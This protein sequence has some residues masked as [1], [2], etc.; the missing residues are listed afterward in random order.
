[1]WCASHRVPIGERTGSGCRCHEL[2][3]CATDKSASGLGGGRGQ[4]PTHVQALLEQR[5]FELAERT[6]DLQRCKNIVS[7]IGPTRSNELTDHSGPKVE[8]PSTERGIRMQA[9]LA[10]A[11]SESHGQGVP[12]EGLVTVGSPRSCVFCPR[13]PETRNAFPCG[14]DAVAPTLLRG[15]WPRVVLASPSSGCGPWGRR[16]PPNSASRWYQR[17][18]CQRSDLYL[19]PSIRNRGANAW[20]F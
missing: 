2:H 15:W 16:T 18:R 10:F 5:T 11:H 17:N 1:M 8:G 6:A 7:P 4:H 12:A 14:A 13:E 9:G 20:A 19:A 3:R